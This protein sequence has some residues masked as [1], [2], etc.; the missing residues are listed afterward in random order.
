MATEERL[1]RLV[2]AG[3][4]ELLGP[5]RLPPT[6]ALVA[7]NV[8]LFPVGAISKRQGYTR[9]RSSKL[10]DAP[11]CFLEIEGKYLAC[12]KSVDAS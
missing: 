2:D 5:T 12:G 7:R 4:A 8:E 10:A 3:L 9:F 11:T 1:Q 6:A